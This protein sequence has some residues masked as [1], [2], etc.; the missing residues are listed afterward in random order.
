MGGIVSPRSLFAIGLLLLTPATLLSQEADGD[1]QPLDSVA[2]LAGCWEAASEDGQ[3]TAEEQWMA[4]RGGLMVGM[5][6]SVR[7]GRT[8]GY[9]FL[10]IRARPDGTLVYHAEPS[11][12]APTDFPARSIEDGRLEF[13]NADH[14]FP[15]KIVY[16]RIDENFIHA[17]VFGEADGAEPA[18]LIPYRRVTCPE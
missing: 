1:S 3:N 10:T 17:A 7:G 15:Q 4:P 18:F 12:Q 9:E 13:V 8:T 5:T 14:D 6:R 2:W 16:A 11:G